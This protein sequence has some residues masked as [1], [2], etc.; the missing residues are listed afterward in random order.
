MRIHNLLEN[1]DNLMLLESFGLSKDPYNVKW[2]KEVHPLLMEVA[3]SPEQIKQL[4]KSIETTASA[5][6][7]NRTLAGK[8]VDKAGEISDKVKDLWFNKLGN[9]LQQSGPVQS[10]D[11][12]Y[13]D[14][15]TK[16][17]AENP[18]LAAALGKY[19]EFADA[20]PKLQKFL[21][22]VA[23]S[24]AGA[25]GLAV[26]GGAAAGI[27]A[28]GLG[29]GAGVAIVN[30][31]DRLLKNEK[32]ST[33][34]GRGAT[35]G[36]VAGLTAA[37]VKAASEMFNS[38]V[39]AFKPGDKYAELM[40]G[41]PPKTVRIN[42]EDAEMLS[43]LHQDA[44]SQMKGQDVADLL[45]SGG[46]TPG[47]DKYLDTAAQVAQKAS[48][49][50]Y[51]QA[52]A[53]AAGTALDTTVSL[54]ILQANAAQAAQTIA[55]IAG[56]LAGDKAG[57]A[58]EKKESYYMQTRPLSEGQV[59]M[60][61][62]RVVTLS[63]GPLWDKVKGAAG[64]AAGAVAQKAG[65]IGT[66]LTTKVTADKLNSAWQK[67]GSPTDSNELAAF[68]K[69]QGVSD[70]VIANTY[71]SMKM[72]APGAASVAEPAAEKQSKIGIGQINKILPTLRT[73]DLLSIQTV[74]QKTMAGKKTSAA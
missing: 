25:L 10:F 21:M 30:I 51:Q 18:K 23:A 41:N 57:S 6:G 44:M 39:D 11:Q 4:F 70:D 19:K 20:N 16:I 14:L 55:P 24:I 74:L 2:M 38:I 53:D 27:A 61:F 29:V 47:L 63:E 58:G 59:Y 13:E 43:K 12:K 26:A 72:P 15:K 65:Q 17:A 42:A 35:A 52:I 36:I 48:D 71:Q 22:M 46:A 62:N 49:P 28:T 33:A 54:D 66:N 37:G 7:S 3:L 69:T 40:M 32:L 50:A 31:V 67:A 68:L 8:A 34:V 9:A 73:R 64:K 1:R 60:V 5:Q 56:A 45:S